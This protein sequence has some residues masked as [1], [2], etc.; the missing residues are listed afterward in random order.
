[1]EKK[2]IKV[3]DAEQFFDLNQKCFF[4][5]NTNTNRFHP[6]DSK[7]KISK[8]LKNR[9]GLSEKKTFLTCDKEN[10]KN[11]LN[12]IKIFNMSENKNTAWKLF[13]NEAMISANIHENNLGAIF[14]GSFL[15][16]NYT[17]GGLLFRN[18]H[19]ILDQIKLKDLDPQGML[20]YHNNPDIRVDYVDAILEKIVKIHDQKIIHQQLILQNIG[21]GIYNGYIHGI[22]FLNFEK[23]IKF[24]GD[25]PKLFIFNDYQTLMRS[26]RQ[27]FGTKQT[28]KW[29]FFKNLHDGLE[30]Q[31]KKIVGEKQYNDFKKLNANQKDDIQLSLIPE[32]LLSYFEED[33]ILY[34]FPWNDKEKIKKKLRKKLKEIQLKKQIYLLEKSIETIDINQENYYDE[35]V[36]EDDYCIVCFKRKRK[37]VF[38]PC[39]HYI[40]CDECASK[41]DNCPTCRIK[42][43]KKTKLFK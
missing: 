17:K 20:R 6:D 2:F 24:I 4:Y 14:F 28:K 23:S 27:T 18:I 13:K 12:V 39:G 22:V 42:I 25:I 5:Q 3:S 40:C 29:L 31:C 43:Q 41:V 7:Q 33:G 15:C 11:C 32:Y 26:I 35:N 38:C 1:M 30:T 36:S 21:T 34:L 9:L 16:E 10:E 37:I 8:E 19:G